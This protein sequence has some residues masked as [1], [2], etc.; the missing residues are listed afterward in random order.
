MT[1]ALLAGAAVALC[2]AI[3]AHAQPAAAPAS[4][5]AAA[6]TAAAPQAATPQAPAGAPA[7]AANL[8]PGMVVK[9]KA[10]GAIGTVNRVGKTAD[11]SDAVE[12][13]IDGKPVGLPANILTVAQNGDVVAPVSKAQIQAAAAG[14]PAAP[15]A[16]PPKTPG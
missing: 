5:P 10:G 4:P 7:S 12:V 2:T 9:D 15:P 11:G 1:R 8:K 13:N 6:P 3:T 16:A 14:Q